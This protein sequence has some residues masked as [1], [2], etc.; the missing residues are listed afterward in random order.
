LFLTFVLVIRFPFQRAAE[1]S[2]RVIR[3]RGCAAGWQQTGAA[4]TLAEAERLLSLWQRID[5]AATLRI[6]SF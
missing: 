4:R 1:A 3:Y 2:A 5:P 6:L